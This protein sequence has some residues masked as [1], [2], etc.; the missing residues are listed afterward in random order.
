MAMS[1]RHV[2]GFASRAW[3]A[4]RAVDSPMLTKELRARMRGG[5]AFVLMFIYI[6]CLALVAAGLLVVKAFEARQA[7][8]A[9]MGQYYGGELGSTLFV[10]LAALQLALVVTIAPGLTCGAISGEWE[11]RTLEMLALTTLSSRSIILGK[12]CA[13]LCYLGMLILCSVPVFAITLV[14]GGVSPLEIALVFL[15]TAAVGLFFG[16]LGLLASALVRRTYIATSLAYGFMFF[17]IVG[18]PVSAASMYGMVTFGG[19]GLA[20]A[21][22]AFAHRVLPRRRPGWAPI[23]ATYIGI[24]GFSYCAIVGLIHVPGLVDAVDS[25]LQSAV[26][27]TNPFHIITGLVTAAPYYPSYPLTPAYAGALPGSYAHPTPYSWVPTSIFMSLA[28]LGVVGSLLGAI[29]LFRTM[30]SPQPDPLSVQAR[31]WAEL[32]PETA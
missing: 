24:F 20:A 3:R 18:L 26:S 32:Y 5:R 7:P 2:A 17:W 12:L 19:L 29:A 8:L 13:S 15:I 22:T 23:R 28:T 1:L 6:A 31:V 30:R 14:L 16:A 27:A 9:A 10:T 11:R 4:V 25:F 21:L